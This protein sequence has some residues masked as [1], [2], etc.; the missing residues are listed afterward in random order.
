MSPAGPSSV[1]LA[2]TGDL[3]SPAGRRA[4]QPVAI[5]T[6]LQGPVDVALAKAAEQIPGP[7]ELPGGSRYEPK[8]DGFRSTLTRVGDETR[9]WSRNGTDLTAAFADVAAAAVRQIP[10]GVVLDGEIVAY[11]DGRLSF[12][13]LQRRL[14]AGRRTAR[15][16]ATEYPASYVAFD[17]L[18]I[19]GVDLRT[20]RWT[21]RRQRLEALASGWRPPLQ[22]TPATDDRAEAELWFETLA[23]MGIE[24]IVTKGAATRYVGGSRIWI[25]TRHRDTQE[26][27]VG[28]VLGPITRPAVVIA[29]RYDEAGDLVIVGRAGPLSPIQSAQLAAALT[30][31]A[32]D[33]PWPDEISAYPWSSRATKQVLTKVDPQVVVEVSADTATQGRHARH[34]MRYRR[35]RPDLTPEDLPDLPST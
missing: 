9:L 34:L 4:D 1:A 2:R 20:Q 33:H 12:D 21:V 8:W 29:G 15:A 24:G 23:S 10:E 5:P 27:I 11:V 31:A 6:G 19:A 28:G 32:P 35:I 14:V 18:A 26:V 30:P 17:L 22:V 25:K 7:N 13:A 3:M 16:R